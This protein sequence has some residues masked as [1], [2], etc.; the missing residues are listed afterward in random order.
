M[1]SVLPCSTTT[2]IR[3]SNATAIV[4]SDS[5]PAEFAQPRELS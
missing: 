5:S 3:L 4:H 2:K 1:L